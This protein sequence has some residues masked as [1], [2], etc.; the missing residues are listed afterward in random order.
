MDQPTNIPRGFDSERVSV[1]MTP[2]VQLPLPLLGCGKRFA[3]KG[4]LKGVPLV[5][6][7][8]PDAV[9]GKVKVSVLLSGKRSWAVSSE[10]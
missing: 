3:S 10:I 2:T 5:K 6:Q 4:T 1:S 9:V 7:A 8:G